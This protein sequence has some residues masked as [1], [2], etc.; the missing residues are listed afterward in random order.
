[1]YQD[2]WAFHTNTQQWQQLYSTSAQR[3]QWL[4]T[5]DTAVPGFAPPPLFSAHLLPIVPDAFL[6]YGGVGGGGA[7]GDVGACGQQLTTLG[8]VYRF[9]VGVTA[10]T[11]DDGPA[12][13]TEGVLVVVSSLSLRL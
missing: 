13:V 7:C 5:P 4:P 1:L 10:L 9:N 11:A 8:Q 2:V 12:R 6:L 3:A